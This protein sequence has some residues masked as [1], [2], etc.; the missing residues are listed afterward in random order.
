MITHAC[1]QRLS[2]L[3]RR[4]PHWFKVAVSETDV[5]VGPLCMDVKMQKRSRPEM[6]VRR[7][8]PYINQGRDRTQSGNQVVM[9]HPLPVAPS[10]LPRA[11]RGSSHTF[12]HRDALGVRGAQAR[13]PGG[14]PSLVFS[15]RMPRHATDDGPALPCISTEFVPAT[16]RMSL[17]PDRRDTEP[18]A[19]SWDS[20]LGARTEPAFRVSSDTSAY[21]PFGRAGRYSPW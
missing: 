17:T 1:Q 19:R 3:R 14:I 12:S 6:K 16:R 15:L 13:R 21:V 11:Q 7:V 8:V 10:P 18:R 4:R 2:L 9:A 5:G 20:G